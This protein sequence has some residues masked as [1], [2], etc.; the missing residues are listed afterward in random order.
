MIVWRFSSTIKTRAMPSSRTA[1]QI[2]Y[3]IFY[4]VVFSGIVSGVYFGF[5]RNPASCC[6][7]ARGPRREGRFRRVVRLSGRDKVFRR[8]GR[9]RV[10]GRRERSEFHD[11]ER[12]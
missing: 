12:R 7:G 4:F 11:L 10:A 5:L 2:V 8:T 6:D 1:K 9:G 3:G